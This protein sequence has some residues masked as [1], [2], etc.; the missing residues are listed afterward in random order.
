MSGMVLGSIFTCI[1]SLAG[2]ERC[3]KAFKTLKE[4]EGEKCGFWPYYPLY[5]KKKKKK[6]AIGL[7]KAGSLS[8]RSVWQRLLPFQLPPHEGSCDCFVGGWGLRWE[9][10]GW[11]SLESCPQVIFGNPLPAQ[12]VD[13]GGRVDA[14][15]AWQLCWPHIGVVTVA[16]WGLR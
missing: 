9:G 14:F 1:H 3:S 5:G 16:D 8:C 13:M 7:C 11:N 10:Q 6:K 15:R 2:C 4:L 12:P